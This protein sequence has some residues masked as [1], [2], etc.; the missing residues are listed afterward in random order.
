MQT[1]QATSNANDELLI[2]DMNY[3]IWRHYHWIY[4]KA[5]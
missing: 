4:V 3:D 5:I 1:E 2:Y